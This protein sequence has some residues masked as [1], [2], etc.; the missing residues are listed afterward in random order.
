[1]KSLLETKMTITFVDLRKAYDSNH[2]GSLIKILRHLGL[3]PKL[4]KLIKLIKSNTN[5]EVKFRNKISQPFEV[6][7]GLR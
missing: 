5:S 3:H 4:I 7:T 2:R 1:M 6:K